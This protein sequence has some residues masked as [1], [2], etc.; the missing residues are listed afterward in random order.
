MW[1]CVDVCRCT[2]LCFAVG[3]CGMVL[4]CCVV[5]VDVCCCVMVCY[6]WCCVMASDVV[7]CCILLCV[8][9]RLCCCMLLRVTSMCVYAS[10]C[11][12]WYVDVW[13]RAV[14]TG[15]L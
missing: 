7:C 3:W 15:M 12:L 8:A 1:S 6:V 14:C 4:R 13:I 9:V 10:R 2:V 11:G 5:C